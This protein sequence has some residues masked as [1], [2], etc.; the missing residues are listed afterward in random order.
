M[1]YP[2]SQEKI[3]FYRDNGFVLL[4]HVV[5]GE[6]LA[7]L[8]EAMEEVMA[9]DSELS[10]DREKGSAYYNILNQ[11]VNT[12]RDSAGMA[13]F[14]LHPRFAE[15]A[16]QLTGAAA[17]RL[18]HDHGLWKM[19]HDSKP[20]PWH[21]D[22]PYWPMRQTGAL[23]MWLALDDVDVSNGCMMFVP[24]SHNVGKLTGINFE[25]PRSIFDEVEGT[26][27]NAPVV[28]P[29]KAGSCTFHHGL[30]FHYAH[31]N[32]TDKPR[33]VLAVIYMP[34]GTVFQSRNGSGIN[35]HVVTKAVPFRDGDPLAGR[36]FPV[37]A[38]AGRK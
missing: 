23:S 36:F 11:K 14:S 4:E 35:D 24:G 29:L 12:W 22:A 16:L 25:Q 7:E 3:S 17:I 20:T 26:A 15:I 18:F 21:Q 1:E 28:V 13:K 27:M 38:K 2:V 10:F 32:R 34:D 31:A 6:E 19:P 33:R 30:T 37:L 5:S 8:R 9:A